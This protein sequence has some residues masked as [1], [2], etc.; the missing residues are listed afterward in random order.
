MRLAL[1]RLSADWQCKCSYPVVIKNQPTRRL[2]LEQILNAASA[3]FSPSEESANLRD[4]SSRSHSPSSPASIT[5]SHEFALHCLLIMVAGN[6]WESERE[7]AGRSLSQRRN[8]ISPAI[9]RIAQFARIPQAGNRNGPAMQNKGMA[10]FPRNIHGLYAMLG[11]QD[12]ENIYVMF[13]DHLHFWHSTQLALKLK[14][15]WEFIVLKSAPSNHPQVGLSRI[16][17]LNT[18]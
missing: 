16:L 4:Q 3:D 6:S 7:R 8:A 14:F 12:Y 2:T 11:R 18:R 10:L 15:P 5:T 17:H 1:E 13:S 9:I